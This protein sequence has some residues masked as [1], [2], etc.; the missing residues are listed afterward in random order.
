MFIALTVSFGLFGQ[1]NGTRALQ[2]GSGPAATITAQ[3]EFYAYAK[4]G[5][6]IETSWTL[7]SLASVV[8][9]AA[10]D[11]AIDGLDGLLI[12]P[13]DTAAAPTTQCNLSAPPYSSPSD[14]V[15]S[16]DYT[17]TSDGIYK[18]YGRVT[19]SNF[20][21]V[22]TIREV[23]IK[24][25]AGQDITGRVWANQILLSQAGNYALA[26]NIAPDLG[27]IP[28]NASASGT[29][30]MV[31]GANS[32]G[33]FFVGETDPQIINRY[34]GPAPPDADHDYTLVVY[35]LDT[36]LDLADGYFLNNFM[37]QIRGHVLEQTE[38]NIK[39]R[40]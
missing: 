36:Q 22:N 30:E 39:S 31:Q 19:P 14:K 4:A 21:R 27:V 8:D 7:Q 33:S 38:L 29:V 25:A 11:Q 32:Y 24:D 40:V 20:G 18:I 15:C 23:A 28:E 1:N 37:K 9:G 5:E 34:G 12:G 17:V 16:I 10:S 2:I 26:A 3:T 6:R 35:A 13:N